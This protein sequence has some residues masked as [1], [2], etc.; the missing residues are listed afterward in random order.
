MSLAENN[1]TS[2]GEWVKAKKHTTLNFGQSVQVITGWM[3]LD[4]HQ[5]FK[6]FSHLGYAKI[7]KF[8]TEFN[9]ISV[10]ILSSIL[11]SDT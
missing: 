1:F 9:V 10:H 7:E 11:S 2:I 5:N 4:A 6:V 3:S 8:R